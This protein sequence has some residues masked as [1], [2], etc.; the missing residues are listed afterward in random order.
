LTQTIITNATCILEG[1]VTDDVTIATA[2]GIITDVVPRSTSDPKA[3]DVGGALVLPGL[4]D[5]HSDGLERDIKPRP[6]SA[7]PVR[8]ALRSFEGRLAAA[9][10]TTIFHGLAFE[11]NP[12][13]GRSVKLA[14]ESYSEIERRNGSAS[15]VDHQVLH[16]LDA[17]DPDALEN[18]VNRLPNQVALVSLEDHT[19]GQGQF[20]D[21]E[22]LKRTMLR[23]TKIGDRA[24]VDKMVA[25]RIAA[26]DRLAANY[27]VALSTMSALA[28][29]GRIRL[30]AHDLENPD[31]VRR[32][33]SLNT[34]VAE[35][36][37]TLDAARTA[38][39][40]GMPVIV[41]APNVLLGGSHSGNVAAEEVV[42]AGLADGLASDYHP[43]ALLGAVF[44]LVDRG[45][46]ELPAA[47][48][49]ATSG[50]ARAAGLTDRG[51]IEPGLRA[52]LIAVRV[53]DDWP[54]VVASW[55]NGRRPLASPLNGDGLS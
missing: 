11:E 42:A 53:E 27:D 28:G 30:V 43:Y 41:G 20:R 34:T 18:L 37:L 5:V 19:P 39:D 17:R 1:R 7:F 55:K 23:D 36:P 52:D 44:Q 12:T 29:D 24:A 21:V 47:I 14:M 15:A 51:K 13:W 35:F 4:I 6:G 40:L 54:Y 22:R 10:I 3:E 38:Q 33:H 26:R 16:R 46:C 8:A 48:A 25:D 9:G 2:D 31:Q 45:A 32:F 49:L 50:P